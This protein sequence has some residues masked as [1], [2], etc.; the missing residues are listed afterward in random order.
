MKRKSLILTLDL[1]D[2]FHILDNPLT[3]TVSEWKNLP[4]R[5]EVAT[6][7]LLD[8]FDQKKV[9]C[10]FFV[11]GYIAQNFPDLIREVVGR[12]HEIGSHGCMH[13]LV[14]NQTEVEFEDDLL[15]S[16]DIIEKASGVRP[17]AYRAPGFSITCKS[18][19]ALTILAKNG[20][21][22]DCSVFPARRAH[23]GFNL[24]R[25]SKP[26]KFVIDDTQT[27]LELP[28]STHQMF[29]HNAVVSGGGYF[30]LLPYFLI[31]SF[32]SESRYNMT[33]FHPRDFDPEQP[34]IPG[35]SMLRR[36]KCN[37]GLTRSFAKLELLLS[38][39]ETQTVGAFVKNLS[40]DELDV[41][42]VSDW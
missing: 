40:L 17:V 14:F 38:R 39:Y 26:F 9:K 35:L 34:K 22:I 42:N 15:A 25:K 21:Q 41:I 3:Q 7:R 32:M 12:G 30:R 13:Q 6:M 23:G 5:V 18:H 31:D 4:S 24:L 29:G 16:L 20:I 28:I 33:Y 2:W 1:E 36:F 27:L 19:W 11:L 10:T 37:V 8:L